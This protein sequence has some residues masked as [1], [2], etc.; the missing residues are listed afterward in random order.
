MF[1]TIDLDAERVWA[2]TSTGTNS[3]TRW[4]RTCGRP[5]ARPPTTPKTLRLVW[6]IWGFYRYPFAA[7]PCMW[8]PWTDITGSQKDSKRI[9]N[10]WYTDSR[11]TISI[12]YLFAVPSFWS[13]SVVRSGFSPFGWKYLN[14][15]SKSMCDQFFV[16]EFQMLATYTDRAIILEQNLYV[17]ENILF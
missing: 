14:D 11:G 7:E 12:I 6:T 13:P 5:S 8:K 16:L 2:S 15:I 3:A 1:M 17:N 10:R 9:S 4:P